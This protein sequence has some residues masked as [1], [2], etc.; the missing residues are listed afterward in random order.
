MVKVQKNEKIIL[1][2]LLLCYLGFGIDADTTHAFH[3]LRD[4]FPFLNQIYKINKLLFAFSYI[5]H[6]LLHFFGIKE[7]KIDFEILEKNEKIRFKDQK[8]IIFMNYCSRAGGNFIKW[9]KQKSNNLT[10]QKFDDKKMEL[11]GFETFGH[12]AGVTIK[13]KD[14]SSYK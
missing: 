12:L 14:V 1:D 5:Y 4:N 9:N 3:Y 2:Q 6:F 13:L 7:Y 10:E 11:I 8:S